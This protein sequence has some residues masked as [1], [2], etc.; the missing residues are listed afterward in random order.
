MLAKAVRDLEQRLKAIEEYL[1]RTGKKSSPKQ[2]KDHS[3]D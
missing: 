1:T 3:D 2:R